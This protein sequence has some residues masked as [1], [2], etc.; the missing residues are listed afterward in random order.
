MPRFTIAKQDYLR[1]REQPMAGSSFVNWIRVLRDN[2]F[3]IE[4]QFIPRAIYVTGMITALAPFRAYEEKKFHTKIRSTR[5]KA[6]LFVI[7]HWRSGTTF[8]HYLLGQDPQL[9]YVSTFETMTPGMII[10]NEELFRNMVKNHLPSK[11]P[12]DDLEMHANL[13]YEEEYAIANMSPYSFYLAWYFPKRWKE[14]FDQYVLFKD[15]SKDQIDGWK[16]TYDYFL[17]KIAYKNN[18]NRIL[19]K[20]LVNTARIKYLLELYP[21]AKFIHIHRNPYKVYLSTWKLYQ[22]ILPI[23][24]FQHIDSETLEEHILYSYKQLFSHYLSQRHLIPKE[25]LLEIPY[26]RF[27]ETPVDHLKHA[28]QTLNLGGFEKARPY[29]EAYAKK[30]ENYKA[31]T[32]R[33]DEKVKEKVYSN[34]KHTFDAFGYDKN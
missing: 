20:S 11:R 6:P 33:I 13:P 25:N 29:L 1:V 4:W 18:G 5:V 21:D 31:S 28:Y 15:R 3:N 2:H 14:Y 17:K 34:W 16:Q 26:E 27:V 32:Y 24:S 19:L 22:K 9:G 8:L 12:M 7:G 23:F 10:A 30:H